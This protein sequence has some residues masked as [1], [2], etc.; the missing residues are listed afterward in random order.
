M[1][2]PRPEWLKE[3]PD[4]AEV[5]DQWVGRGVVDKAKFD[6]MAQ[7]IRTKAFSAAGDL[8]TAQMKKLKDLL[9]KALAEGMT[10]AQWLKATAR[11]FESEGYAALV[12]RTNVTTALEG[13]RY[14][15]MLDP[16]V[17]ERW[18]AW[19][20]NAWIDSKNADEEG[21]PDGICRKLDGKIFSKDD[22]AAYFLLPMVHW[23]CRCRASEVPARK[24]KNVTAAS[25]LGVE[26]QEDW[27]FDKRELIP[28][29]LL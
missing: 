13:A 11:F 6:R 23:G 19:K 14:G 8:S 18:P 9:G 12:F 15:R 28:G 27:N 29:G 17:R 7:S 16:A 3:F 21:C 10:E 26:P 24:A 22:E 1:A 4:L 20:F 25:S 2:T 5:Y